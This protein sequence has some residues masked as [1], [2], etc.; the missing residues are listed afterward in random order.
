MSTKDTKKSTQEIINCP[1]SSGAS[2]GNNGALGASLSNESAVP[3]IN[4]L[5]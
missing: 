1:C 2:N 3:T 4:I 5:H